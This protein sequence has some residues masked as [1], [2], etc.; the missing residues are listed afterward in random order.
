[1]FYLN[2]SALATNTPEIVVSAKLKPYMG[3]PKDL[4]QS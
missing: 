1:M 4:T 2:P 3:V